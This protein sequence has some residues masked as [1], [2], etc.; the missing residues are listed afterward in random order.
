MRD[1]GL[2]PEP[3]ILDSRQQRF[4]ARLANAC[5]N[6]LRKL[7][8]NPSSGTL[9]CR[10][11]KKEHEH[12]RTTEGMSS[13]ARAKSQWSEPS[14]WTTPLQSREPRS[15]GQ[16]RKRPKEERESGC[17]GQTD[18]AQTTA[19]WEPQQYA[20]TATSGG[21][22]A[23]IEARDVWRSLTPNYGRSDSRSR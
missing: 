7:H 2:T 13:P 4:A 3:V 18:R 14:Y 21:P 19:E 20:S 12:G 23:A 17:G 8:Q 6:K 1:S 22:A 5:S 9:V 11:V 15:A 16:E 10:A